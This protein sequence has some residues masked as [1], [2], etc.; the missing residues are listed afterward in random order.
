MES[1][2]RYR[3]Q[4]LTAADIDSIRAFITARPGASRRALSRE[5]CV[6]RGWVQANGELR[7]AVCRGL[8]LALHRGGH[9]ELPAARWA[10][11]GAVS[12]GHRPAPLALDTRA[13]RGTLG[14]LGALHFQQVRRSAEEALVDALLAQH[15][16]LGCPRPVGEHL[17]FLV[18]A[19]ERPLACFVWSSAARHLGPR[20]RY[21]GWSAQARRRNL[22]AVAYNSR[23]L[24]LPWVE[25][26]HLAS[27]LLGHMTRRLSQEWMAA[28][29][30]A[31]LFAETF[32]DPSRYRG[33]CYRAANWQWLGRT[34][35]R[36][37]DDH[38]KRANRPC[39]E[40]YGRAL[41]RRFRERLAATP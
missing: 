32:V 21:L 5:L 8:L 26:R 28:Y 29:G 2:F 15:H 6:A 19:A 1:V 10:G 41:H 16:Y 7:D 4:S 36:G 37:K 39:K 35:G 24:I 34:T 14:E 12:R 11:R 20:D 3:G 27:H 31:V 33:T 30:H 25:V 18:T 22:A 17:K 13:V 9:I 38:T 23:F 40:V